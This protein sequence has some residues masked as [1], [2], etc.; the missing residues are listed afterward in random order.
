MSDLEYRIKRLEQRQELQ[1]K[2]F[3]EQLSSFAK[4]IDALWEH[5]KANSLTSVELSLYCTALESQLNVL[6]NKLNIDR[7]PPSTENL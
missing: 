3:R 5:A 7:P 6:M 4:D 1:M 2:S